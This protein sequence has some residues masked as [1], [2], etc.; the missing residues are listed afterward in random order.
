MSNS[1]LADIAK[2]LDFIEANNTMEISPEHLIEIG[3]QYGMWFSKGPMNVTFMEKEKAPEAFAKNFLSLIE[4]VGSSNDNPV[5]DPRRINLEIEKRGLDTEFFV[6]GKSMLF[7]GDTK[8]LK[9][10][11]KQ[12]VE[13]FWQD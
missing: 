13:K 1:M 3:Q 4:T 6:T 8:D 5:I 2:R 12:Y 7:S 9:K 11:M 10:V